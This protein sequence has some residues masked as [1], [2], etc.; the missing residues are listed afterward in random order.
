MK[1]TTL[2]Y[3]QNKDQYLMLHRIKKKNDLNQDKWIGVGGKFEENES[4]EECLLRECRE[5]TGLEL[6]EYRYR[7]LVTFVADRWEGEYMHLFTAEGFE[8]Q[9]GPCDEGVLEWI[10]KQ[11]LRKLNLWEGDHIFLDLLEAE[12]P[13]FTMKLEYEGDRLVEAKFGNTDI[14]LPYQGLCSLPR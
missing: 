6:T 2:C 8:G 9:I 5:E 12:E 7:G 10:S 13:F 3:I 4:P 1:N 11:E 14:P